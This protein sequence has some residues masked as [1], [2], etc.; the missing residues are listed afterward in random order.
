MFTSPRDNTVS[1]PV[2]SVTVTFQRGFSAV[3]VGWERFLFTAKM[4]EGY[5]GVCAL[6]K[7]LQKE[8]WRAC[9]L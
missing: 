6:A 7:L 4:E 8:K 9:S 1:Q 5:F 2:T 3:A